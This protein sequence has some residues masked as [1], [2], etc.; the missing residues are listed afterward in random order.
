MIPDLVDRTGRG[1]SDVAG[2]DLAGAGQCGFRDRACGRPL[3]D[4]MVS[5]STYLTV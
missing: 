1:E 2:S 3:V 5:T 4:K